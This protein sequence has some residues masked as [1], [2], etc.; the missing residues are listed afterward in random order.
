[1]QEWGCGKLCIVQENIERICGRNK[2]DW[3]LYVILTTE[4]RVFTETHAEASQGVAL[5]TDIS[6]SHN[7]DT[8]MRKKNIQK[9]WQWMGGPEQHVVCQL[10]FR[11]SLRGSFREVF[12]DDENGRV[13]WTMKLLDDIPGLPRAHLFS[14]TLRVT[15]HCSPHPACINMGRCFWLQAMTFAE[16][17]WIMKAQPS[18]G[19]QKPN[20]E[21]FHYSTDCL[22]V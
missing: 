10:L 18:L 17:I 5:A 21:V 16:G 15:P 19:G 22:V 4:Q 8:I 1:M 3:D 9:K 14:R 11:D 13:W 12:R 6:C 7:K 20:G 2:R